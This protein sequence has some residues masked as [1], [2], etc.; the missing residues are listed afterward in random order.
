MSIATKDLPEVIKYLEEISVFVPSSVEESISETIEVISEIYTENVFNN[1]LSEN[2]DS[3]YEWYEQKMAE[4]WKS[5]NNW[6]NMD[7]FEEYCEEQFKSE[8]ADGEQTHYYKV[9]EAVKR[10]TFNI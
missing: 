7:D 10:G 6:E 2:E 9:V 1:Y 4:E 3:L 5:T 8:L